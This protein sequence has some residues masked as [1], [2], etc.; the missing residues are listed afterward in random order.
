VIFDVDGTLTIPQPWMFTRM[1]ALLSIPE[2]SG[3]DILAHVRSLPTDAQRLEAMELVRGVET[4]AMQKM[5]LQ[6]G[7]GD[8]MLYLEEKHVRK[9]I[10]TRNYL[11]PVTHLLQW[12]LPA[13]I[14]DPIVTRDFHPPKPD[15]SGIRYIAERWGV[16]PGECVM[17]GDSLDDMAA[18]RKAGAA[19]VLL[20]NDGN[21]GLRGHEYTDLV[22]ERLDELIGI[23]GNGFYGIERS[24]EKT[25]GEIEEAEEI[26]KES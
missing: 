4:E 11:D 20:A 6:G 8:L 17:V 14:F 2:D 7:A 5:A 18:G 26:L 23:L 24:P 13:H 10:L 22:I 25:R 16:D 19:T 1:R 21:G 15:P 9:G 12:H 3:V